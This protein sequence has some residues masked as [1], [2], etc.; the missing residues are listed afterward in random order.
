[1]KK[2]LIED[3]LQYLAD[4]E[5]ARKRFNKQYELTTI[6]RTIEGFDYFNIWLDQESV[7][8]DCEES[9]H[10]LLNS[11]SSPNGKPI[12]G[13]LEQEEKIERIKREDLKFFIEYIGETPVEMTACYGSIC[14]SIS[15]LNYFEEEYDK[16]MTVEKQIEEAEEKLI[17]LHSFKKQE[18]KNNAK[19]LLNTFIKHI[20]N[21]EGFEKSYKEINKLYN[22]INL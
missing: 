2:D 20:S 7:F 14:K 8:K 12:C 1:M 22:E 9:I 18:Y 11:L 4:N 15:L 3:M 19:T 10:F 5:E 16:I 13:F 17:N 6:N 21:G